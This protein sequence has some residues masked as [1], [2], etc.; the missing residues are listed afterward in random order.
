MNYE[1]TEL[2]S[3][4][5]LRYFSNFID[6]KYSPEKPLASF[7]FIW[8]HQQNAVLEIDGLPVELL[9]GQ[10][11]ALNPEQRVDFTPNTGTVIFEFNRDFYCIIDH[12]KEVSCVGVLFLG[13]KGALHLTLNKYETTKLEALVKIFSEEF[14]TD[15]N[16]QGEMLRILLKRMI[17]IL[18]RLAKKQLYGQLDYTETDLDVVRTYNRLVEMNYRKQHKVADYAEMMNKS[19]KTLS[20]L[21]H[22]FH[23]KTPLQVIH[24]RIVME[25]KRMMKFTDKSAKE[26]GYDLGFDDAS[27]FSR[28]FKT[29]TGHYPTAYKESLLQTS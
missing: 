15:D 17:I 12:D 18:T 8:Q 25:A 4:A 7:T 26:I 5:F 19:P 21:F 3:G 22:Q 2:Q 10:L 20:N 11:L 24:E 28:F 1:Y 9:Q 23:N 13:A 6:K 27:K 14:E 29:Q 16:V